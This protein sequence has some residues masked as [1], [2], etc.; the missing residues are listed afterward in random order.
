M[1]AIVADAGWL[2]AGVLPVVAITITLGLIERYIRRRALERRAVADDAI[3][4]TLITDRG[5]SGPPE[6]D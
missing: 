1:A 6:R 3:D 5:A 2:V 4:K